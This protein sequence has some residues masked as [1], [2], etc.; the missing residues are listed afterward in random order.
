MRRGAITDTT[1]KDYNLSMSVNVEAPFRIVRA[2][3]P[4]MADSWGWGDC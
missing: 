4:L 1:D 2:A 3:I